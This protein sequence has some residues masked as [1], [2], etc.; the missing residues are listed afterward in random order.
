MSQG[1]MTQI[2]VEL[3]VK[4]NERRLETKTIDFVKFS[5]SIE[6]DSKPR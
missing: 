5:K 3:R 6:N 1:K 4:G 2:R